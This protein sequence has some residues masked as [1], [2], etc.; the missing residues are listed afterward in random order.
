MEILECSKDHAYKI[1]KKL[2]LSWLKWVMKL[3]QEKCQVHK[4]PKR[5]SVCLV[6]DEEHP[7]S[8]ASLALL[9]VI[10]GMAGIWVLEIPIW[11]GNI[12]EIKKSIRIFQYA[13]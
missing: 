7:L 13:K 1:I 10:K 2:I 3:K 12:M 11:R 5:R 9:E 8:A 6:T 4:K